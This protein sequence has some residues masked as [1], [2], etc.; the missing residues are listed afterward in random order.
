L[1]L[2]VGAAGLLAHKIR[3]LGLDRAV[4]PVR[5]YNFSETFK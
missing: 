3:C 2:L 5:K 4:S 1:I